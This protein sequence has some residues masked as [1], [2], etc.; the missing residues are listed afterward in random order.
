MQRQIYNTILYFGKNLSLDKPPS[1]FQP[2]IGLLTIYEANI[3]IPYPTY[4]S[5]TATNVCNLINGVD[6]FRA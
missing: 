2:E 6:L 4:L 3:S 5:G 1:L